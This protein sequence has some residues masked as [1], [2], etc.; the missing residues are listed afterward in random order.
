MS[1]LNF[2]ND[3]SLLMWKR[4]LFVL[5]DDEYDLA[6]ILK[7][8]TQQ[9]DLTIKELGEEADIPSSTLYKLSSTNADP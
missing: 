5:V 4:I 1:Q 3:T 9:F 7:E 8:I 2:S 6:D